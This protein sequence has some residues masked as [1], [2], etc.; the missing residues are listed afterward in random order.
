MGLFHLSP[1]IREDFVVGQRRVTCETSGFTKQL[2]ETRSR[3]CRTRTQTRGCVHRDRKCIER[4]RYPK[5]ISAPVATGE[6]LVHPDEHVDA[7][8]CKVRTSDRSEIFE[9]E[10]RRLPPSPPGFLHWPDARRRLVLQ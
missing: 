6:V 3:V 2:D 10:N 9:A 7:C 4:S 1:T 5:M 8:V